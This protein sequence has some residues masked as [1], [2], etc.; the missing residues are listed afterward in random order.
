M[1]RGAGAGAA[2]AG[3]FQ[4][5]TILGRLLTEVEMTTVD[6]T[7]PRLAGQAEQDKNLAKAL[8]VERETQLR[9]AYLARR[10]EVLDAIQAWYQQQALLSSGVPQEA[11]PHPELLDA[12]GLDPAQN[13]PPAWIEADRAVRLAGELL[14]YLAGNV[15]E[16]LCLEAF[17]LSVCERAP[18]SSPK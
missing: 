1:Q 7:D 5:R 15:E 11:L 10:Q 8:A 6:T 4:L 3:A 13:P 9:A 2:L 14:H 17:C 16:R 12:A 18:Q